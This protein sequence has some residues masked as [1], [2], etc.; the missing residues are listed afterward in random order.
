MMA[1]SGTEGARGWYRTLGERIREL[2]VREG[3]SLEEA[4]RAMQVPE[5]NLRGW[6]SGQRKIPAY[7][8]TCLAEHY[9]I[10]LALLAGQ[11]S[12]LFKNEKLLQRVAS[13]GE[14]HQKVVERVVTALE[15]IR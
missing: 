14:E 4:S 3:L 6:E 13:L 11:K 10:S 12:D 7:E 2:R 5:E 1:A 8:L 15:K 9:R